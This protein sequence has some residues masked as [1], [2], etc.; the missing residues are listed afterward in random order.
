MVQERKSY[1]HIIIK[2]LNVQNK[3]IFLKGAW[4]KVQIMYKGRPITITPKFS[5]GI[6]KVRMAWTTDFEDFKC[7]PTL[8]YPEKF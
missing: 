4:E 8:L 7:L 1:K 3:E 2:I 6:L 5:M